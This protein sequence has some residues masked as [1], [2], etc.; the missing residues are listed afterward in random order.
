MIL[1]AVNRGHSEWLMLVTSMRLTIG[2]PTE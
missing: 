2:Y 1:L